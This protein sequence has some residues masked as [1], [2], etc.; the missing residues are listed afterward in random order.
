MQLNLNAR[1][2]DFDKQI[3]NSKVMNKAY[4]VKP[5]LI[6]TARQQQQKP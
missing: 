6:K 2:T 3:Q 5:V 1:K 4:V